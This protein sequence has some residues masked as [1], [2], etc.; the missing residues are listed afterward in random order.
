VIPVAALAA[1]LVDWGFV[2]DN[3]EDVWAD[4]AQHVLLTA[5]SVGLGL[6]LS[7]PL[8]VLSIRRPRLYPIV[9][10]AAGLLYTI[11]ALA[12]MVTLLPIFGLSIWPVVVA[13]TIYTLLILIRN[14][15]A[16]VRG[17][18][19]DVREAAT[20]M[21]L[22]GRQVLWRV[23]VPLALPAIMAG[24][25]IATVSTVGLVTI[26]GLFGRGGLG[27]L[28]FEGLRLADTTR[29][30]VG[31]VLSVALALLAEALLLLLQRGLSPWARRA[32]V[33]AVGV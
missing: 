2:V 7:F 4:L 32:G 17:V 31:A 11:P 14:I 24:V 16:G 29:I 27:Q 6:L 10:S 13:L 1:E 9:T 12:L 5:L 28:M 25:R 23:E 33:R 19:A 20:G 3:A 15:V 30:V 18:P 26:G 22:T 8:A 21:G